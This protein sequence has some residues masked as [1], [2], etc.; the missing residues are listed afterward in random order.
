MR[1]FLL[2]L[3]SLFVAVNVLAMDADTSG[4][5]PN[6]YAFA[7][8]TPTAAVT[9]IMILKEDNDRITG[10]MVNEFGVSAVDFVYDRSRRSIKLLNVVSFLDK[11]YIKRVLRKDLSLCMQLLFKEQCTVSKSYQVA[12]DGDTVAVT[13]IKRKLKYTYSAMTNNVQTDETER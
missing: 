8:E 6:R 9:G 4:C 1:R 3:S 7:I 2:F 10:S 11:W 13:N 12:T 5:Q